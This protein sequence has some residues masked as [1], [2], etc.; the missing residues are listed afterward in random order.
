MSTAI[1]RLRDANK[2]ARDK[3]SRL[4]QGIVRKA[5]ISMTGAAL[6]Y[7]K[8]KGMPIELVGVPT[9]LALGAVTT[10]GELVTKG[11]MQRFFGAV[12]DASLAVYAHEAMQEGS[13]VAGIDPVG[14]GDI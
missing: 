10:I 1:D 11:A 6:G 3:S 7:G 12:S 13:F 14:G 5:T 9:K 2:R 4:E 8:N